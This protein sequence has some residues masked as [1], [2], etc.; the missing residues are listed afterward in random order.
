LPFD[1]VAIGYQF[2]T[3]A[4]AYIALAVFSTVVETGLE[5]ESSSLY[6]AIEC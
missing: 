1:A 3:I 2:A 4:T 6:C 5:K